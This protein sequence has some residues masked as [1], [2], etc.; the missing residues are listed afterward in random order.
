MKIEKLVLKGFQQFTDFH[1]DLTDPASGAPLEKVCLIGRNA[2]G[3]STLLRLLYETLRHIRNALNSSQTIGV[4]PFMAMKLRL[5]SS[6][7][8]VCGIPPGNPLWTFREDVEHSH[9]WKN[10]IDESSDIH[11]P[12]EFHPS[13]GLNSHLLSKEERGQV[14]TE[15]QWV[16]GA[17]DLVVYSP[18]DDSSLIAHGKKLPQTTLN[19]ALSLFKA[20]PVCVE[21]KTEAVEQFWNVLIYLIK[22]RENDWHEFLR[23]PENRSKSVQQAEGEFQDGHPEILARIAELWDRVLAQAG[24]EFDYENARKPVQLNENLEAYV[25]LRGSGTHVD[26]NALSSGIRRFIFRLGHIYSLFFQRHIRR[27]FLLLDEPENSLH[28]DFLYDLVEIY[29]NIVENTQFFVATHS[30]IIAA[31]FRP[32]ERVILDFNEEHCVTNRRGV[33]PA[34]DDPNDLLDK[35][36]QVRSL[37]GREGLANWERFLE[38]R[39]LIKKTS[40]ATARRGLIDEYMRIGNAYNFAA[41][42]VS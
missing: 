26:Y 11:P 10:Y 30:P 17:P 35:D 36:F 18:A 31:Q 24:L 15:L 39:R 27:G 34:G 1:L 22:K 41:D 33:V 42:A 37:Y 32:E 9:E 28:P 38:L 4:H 8:W 19:D 7:I 16:S 25:R 3:K 2:T 14:S 23:Q 5:A 20:F 12:P 29:L 21:V 6:S 13:K 40:D